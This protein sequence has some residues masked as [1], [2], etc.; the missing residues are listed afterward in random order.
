MTE[1]KLHYSGAD[2]F[3]KFVR[4]LVVGPS[5]S[6]KTRFAL[7]APNA[8]W[9]AVKPGF[10]TLALAG[11]VPFIN[12]EKE[13]DL[14]LLKQALET[15]AINS[16]TL[17][18]DC[19]DEL[20]KLLLDEHLAEER[21][22]NLKADDWNWI[23][24]RMNAI[25]EGLSE[26]PI[27]IIWIAHTK[28]VGM[29]DSLTVKPSIQGSFG[30]QIHRYVDYSLYLESASFNLNTLSAIH[31]DDDGGEVIIESEVERVQ[32]AFFRT[33][34]TTKYDWVHDMT[35]T[36]PEIFPLNF[37]DDFN[38]I[39]NARG[40]VQLA[41]SQV[42]SLSD[43]L[44]QEVVDSSEKKAVPGMSSQDKIDKLLKKK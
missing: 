25:A 35:N 16:T 39:Q 38:R 34:P 26:L 23:S 24:Q 29:E 5:G 1:L 41:A 14:F 4:M 6:G 40:N 9:A 20:Q 31:H 10:T 11:G 37:S 32:D 15:K 13:E 3:S 7:T 17:V 8:I 27:N 42:V 30:E 33:R 43:I 44:D 2:E 28:D 18:I 12:I 36:L 22:D 19:V 21:R